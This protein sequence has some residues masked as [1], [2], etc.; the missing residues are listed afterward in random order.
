MTTSST[1]KRAAVKMQVMNKE[2][3][4]KMTMGMGR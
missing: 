4:A 3:K 2:Q 1:G